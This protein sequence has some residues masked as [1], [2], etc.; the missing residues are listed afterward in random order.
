M[1][2]PHDGRAR[3]RASAGPGGHSGPLAEGRTFDDVLRRPPHADRLPR[4]V[5]RKTRF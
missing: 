3:E 4:P 5:E 1:S 2:Q